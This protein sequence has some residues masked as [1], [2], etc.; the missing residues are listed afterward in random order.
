MHG[1]MAL[2]KGLL[3]RL[4]HDMR[5][6]VLLVGAVYK[7]CRGHY[8]HSTDPRILKKIN[9][10]YLPF[11][12]LHRTGF[13]RAFVS[14]VVHLAHE[15]L[16]VCAIARHVTNLREEYGVEQILKLIRDYGT[17]A[18]KDALE[19][20]FLAN[21]KLVSSVLHPYPTNDVIARCILIDFQKN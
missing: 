2:N 10:L 21:P 1:W 9:Q 4:L 5:H 20:N 17:Y 18:Q 6:I 15:G 12:L 11:H 8:V 14:E 3:P 7:C 19:T 13:T 16:P